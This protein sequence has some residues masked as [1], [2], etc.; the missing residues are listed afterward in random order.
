MAKIGFFLLLPIPKI[1]ETYH[2][3]KQLAIPSLFQFK[4][5]VFCTA[6]EDVNTIEKVM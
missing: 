1:K 3:A 2:I 5:N 4:I 6:A